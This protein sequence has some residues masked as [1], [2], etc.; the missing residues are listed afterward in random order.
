MSAGDRYAVAVLRDTLETFISEA[1]LSPLQSYA[2]RL[3]LS[4]AERC[5][6]SPTADPVKDIRNRCD[7]VGRALD[8]VEAATCR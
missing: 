5:I 7:A 2:F 8:A 4:E 6:D 3:T 1:R